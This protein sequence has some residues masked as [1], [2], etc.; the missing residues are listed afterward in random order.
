MAKSTKNNNNNKKT[1]KSKDAGCMVLLRIQ[2][3][4]FGI[5]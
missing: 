5:L 4:S 1:L 2:L 3:A